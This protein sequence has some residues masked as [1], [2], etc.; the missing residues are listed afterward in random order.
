MVAEPKTNIRNGPE[1]KA[2]IIAAAQI[3]F[4]EKGYPHAGV[5]EIAQRAEVANSLVMKYFKTKA[6]LFE[7]ALIASLIDPQTFQSDRSKFAE[8]LASAI[9]D[10]AVVMSSPAMIALSLGDAEARAVATKVVHEHI[11]EPM[12]EWLGADAGPARAASIFMLTMGFTIFNKNLPLGY[13]DAE[14]RGMM[15]IYIQSVQAI[16]DSAASDQLLTPGNAGR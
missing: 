14:K 9:V 4:S 13:S 6:N 12:T 5:R 10:P 15:D 8:T 2:R 1:T 3:I 7:T 11:I 16:I